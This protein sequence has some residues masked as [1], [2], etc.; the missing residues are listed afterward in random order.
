MPK[1]VGD[2]YKTVHVEQCICWCYMSY[3]LKD[4][5]FKGLKSIL[6]ICVKKCA[7]WEVCP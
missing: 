3:L 2:V 4:P 7:F 5:K 1:H 6:I